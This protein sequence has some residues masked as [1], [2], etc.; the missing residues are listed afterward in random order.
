MSEYKHQH[1]VMIILD[2]IKSIIYAIPP[3]FFFALSTRGELS[4]V[5]ISYFLWIAVIFFVLLILYSAAKWY[6]YTYQYKDGYLN[7]RRGLLFKKERSIK[8]ERVQTVN[9]RTNILLKLLGVA[10][11]QVKTAGSGVESELTLNA[12]TI[13]ETQNI[14][15][16]LETQPIQKYHDEY[17]AEI[18][19]G[20]KEAKVNS[21]HISPWNLFLAGATSGR[22]MLLFSVIAAVFSQIYPYIPDAYLRFVLEQI[23]P[24][25]GVNVILLAMLLLG[26]LLL[27]WAISTLVFMVRYANFT[28][29]RQDDDFR[30]SWGVIEQKEYNLN[31]NRV[32]ALSVQD[33][34]LRQPFGL[35]SIS[36]EVAGGSSE[37]QDYIT[38]LYPLLHFSELSKFLEDI[39]PEYSM[40]EEEDMQLLP[41]RSRKRYVIRS[42][43]PVLVLVL[44]LQ[45]LPHGW[46]SLLLLP[47]AILLGLSRYN[48]GRTAILDKQLTFRYR[49]INRY[50]V[51]V[52]KNHIQSLQISSNPFQRRSDL[53]TVRVSVL[54]S[55][56]GKDFKIADVDNMEN[57][58]I[59]RWFS[60]S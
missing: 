40:P 25:T 16:Y 56:A 2:T 35:C 50:H 23:I 6:F 39:F 54:S 42:S 17:Q 11:V 44:L 58:K 43:I 21:Y 26:L 27:S 15:G 22:F 9:I 12:V 19:H 18:E 4:G 5:N 1:P 34:L 52:L 8:R 7:I 57:K 37:K 24:E 45:L 36:A 32:Q 38:R 13:E 33:G 3:L 59:W 49:N 10:S 14:K 31:L 47:P 46:V 51:F 30:I 53:G 20:E 55:P 41:I 29:T 48:A 28:I 60:R